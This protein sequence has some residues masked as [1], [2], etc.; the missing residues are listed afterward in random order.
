LIQILRI[1]APQP[2]NVGVRGLREQ[3]ALTGSGARQTAK[4]GIRQC[5]FRLQFQENG[6]SQCAA[7]YR[8]V[9]LSL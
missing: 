2:V 1:K 9:T 8:A 4:G 5:R 7:L 6:D 3:A